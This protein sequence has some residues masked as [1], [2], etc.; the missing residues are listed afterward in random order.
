[1]QRPARIQCGMPLGNVV[2]PYSRPSTSRAFAGFFLTVSAGDALCCLLQGILYWR[3]ISTMSGNSGPGYRKHPDHRVEIR[4]VRGRVRVMFNGDVIADSLDAVELQ[5]SN[6]GTVYYFPRDDVKMDRLARSPHRT[7][8]PFKGD[9][10]YYSVVN[11]PKNAVW[12]Y[13][14]PY[15]DVRAIQGR[16]AFYPDKVDCIA[17]APD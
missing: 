2:A 16:L 6:H 9:A 4:P 8:C 5:E 13:E 1:M 14:Q 7:Y 11:G 3:N 10:S 15:D 17:T 12:V